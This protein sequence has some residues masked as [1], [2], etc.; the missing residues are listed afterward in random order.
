LVASTAE[1]FLEFSFRESVQNPVKKR[2]AEQAVA[3]CAKDGDVIMLDA[4]ST[5]MHT[6]PFLS[7]YNN[8]IVITSGIKTALLLSGTH[9][10]F[11]STGGRA[12]NVASSYIGQTAIDTLKEF[13]ADVC[14]VSIR[15]LS[16]QGYITDSSE[17]ENDVR[18]AIMQQSKR[19][20]LLID[21]S[22]IGKNFWLNLCHISEFDDVFCDKPLPEYIAKQVR[23]FHLV[24]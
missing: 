17:R 10:K 3:T 6:V 24:K 20:V 1:N 23:N 7:N 12:L 11:Y 2:L 18:Y 15:G 4:S 8:V 9:I 14:F 19:K 22:K 5:A 13:N 16:D 21:S